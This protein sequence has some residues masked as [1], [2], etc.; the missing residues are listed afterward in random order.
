MSTTEEQI[1]TMVKGLRLHK[2]YLVDYGRRIHQ[3][4]PA[5]SISP[6]VFANITVPVS[7]PVAMMMLGLACAMVA[8]TDPEEEEKPGQGE[9]L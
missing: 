7:L 4:Y 5:K 8:K 1:G 3:M 9:G 6:E 2:V